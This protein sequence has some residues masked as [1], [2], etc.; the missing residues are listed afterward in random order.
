MLA[1]AEHS[2]PGPGRAQQIATIAAALNDYARPLSAPQRA[3]MMQRLRELDRNVRLPTQ[4][5]LELSLEIA[6]RGGLA[7][8]PGVFQQTALRDVWAFTSGDGM[9]VLLYRTGRI[10][11][12]MH[13]LL[14]EVTA[15]RGFSSTRSRRT[16]GPTWRPLPPAP[17]CPAGS[18]R[19]S[20][21]SR[22]CRSTTRAR[23]GRRWRT[24]RWRPRALAA[25]VLIAVIT[26]SA[27]RR[28]LRLARLKTDLV[29]AVSHEL[30]T[31]LASMRVLVDGLLADAAAR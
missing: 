3:S 1:A 17:R 6:E 14:H 30:R 16:S 28:Q 21:R 26:G 2:E 27:F 29:A 23:G 7:L 12:M 19:S 22:R 24:W 15:R 13:D 5:S 8:E 10:E 31:P 20:S 25:T 11:A 4:A 9:T 18:S